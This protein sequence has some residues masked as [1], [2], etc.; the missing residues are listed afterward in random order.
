MP[1]DNTMTYQ[2]ISDSLSE[3][4]KQQ[5]AVVK[6]GGGTLFQIT[7]IEH[8]KDTD[9]YIMTIGIMPDEVTIPKEDGPVVSTIDDLFKELNI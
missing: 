9:L 8:N 4:R 6:F 2:N 7:G 3:K 1:G 5:L